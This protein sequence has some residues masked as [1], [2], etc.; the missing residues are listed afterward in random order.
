MKAVV[1][2]PPALQELDGALAVFRDPAALQLAVNAALDDIASGRVTHARI[3]RSPA[4][5]C[6]LTNPPYSIIYVE[7]DDEIRV[8]AFPHS[9]R[10]PGYWKSRLPKP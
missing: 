2:E 5:R 9:S 1:W 6:I 10:K 8:Y 7:T 3:P 4:R